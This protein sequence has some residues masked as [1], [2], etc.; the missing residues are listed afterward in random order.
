M[1]ALQQGRRQ[2]LLAPRKDHPLPGTEDDDNQ[3]CVDSQGGKHE[4]H[5]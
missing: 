1:K 5:T 3:R 4:G 2:H